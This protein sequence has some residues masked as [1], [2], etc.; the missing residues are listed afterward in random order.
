MKVKQYIRIRKDTI[1]EVSRLDCV[2]RVEYGHN[3]EIVVLLKPEC[4]KGNR[5]VRK[6]EYL[7]QWKSGLWQRYGSEAFGRLFKN[8]GKEAGNQWQEE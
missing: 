3:G 2:E 4:T 8:P 7:V 1:D 5:Q 6:D